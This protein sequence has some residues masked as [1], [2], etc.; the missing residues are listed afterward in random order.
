MYWSKKLSWQE[1]QPLKGPI[2][3]IHRDA[4]AMLLGNGYA[5]PEESDEFER[6]S[7]RGSL[8]RSLDTYARRRS[9]QRISSTPSNL[10]SPTKRP[11]HNATELKSVLPVVSSPIRPIR[12]MKPAR[13]P[14]AEVSPRSPLPCATSRSYSER[15]ST[16]RFQ[17]GVAETPRAASSTAPEI[18]S[19][20][21]ATNVDGL[22]VDG[23][24]STEVHVDEASVDEAGA[25][26]DGAILAKVIVDGVIV[27][28]VC[29]TAMV[30]QMLG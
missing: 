18:A 12:S 21:E 19:P 7:D 13:Q 25:D 26:V 6:R 5:L 1:G 4:D 24:T 8:A 14:S 30:A 20:V 2:L 3:R 10:V 16:R 9:S 15:P 17:L 28:E 27:S 22:D 11:S 29:V 23:A